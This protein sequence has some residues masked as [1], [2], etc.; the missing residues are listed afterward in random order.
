MCTNVLFIQIYYFVAC[1]L[2]FWPVIKHHGIHETVKITVEPFY[3]PFV[4]QWK[5]NRTKRQRDATPIGILI[6]IF[7]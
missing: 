2:F 6:L 1:S 5:H 7:N 3:M 4:V